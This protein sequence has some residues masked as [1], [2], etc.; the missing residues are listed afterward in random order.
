[1]TTEDK[2]RA[3]FRELS[4]ESIRNGEPYRWFD[5]LYKEAERGETTI[6]WDDLEPNAN[7]VAFWKAHSW[8]ATGQ[9]AMVVACGL[10]DDAEQIAAWGFRTTAF[11]VSPTAIA[12][13]RKR[14]PESVIE[15][16]V[17]DLFAAPKEWAEAF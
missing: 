2:K 3:R 6:P 13:A 15:Y 4:A 1:M 7:M 16:Q 11:D 8:N 14:F 12:M 5:V 17:A 9:R 10:G